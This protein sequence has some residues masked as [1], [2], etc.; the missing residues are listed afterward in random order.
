MTQ[1]SSQEKIELFLI[2]F[3]KGVL[4]KTQLATRNFG[5]QAGFSS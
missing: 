2:I 3:M 5:L 4:V 1:G